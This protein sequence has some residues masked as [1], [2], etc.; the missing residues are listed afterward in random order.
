MEYLS[1]QET[2][3]VEV[4]H[5][6]LDKFGVQ[7]LVKREDLNHKHVSGNKW[8][9][10]KYNLIE[11]RKQGKNT[12]LTFGG[13][14]SNHIYATAAAAQILGFK[15]IGVIRGEETF[16]LNPT[17]TFA[18]ENGMSLHY[19]SREAYRKKSEY[20]TIDSLRTLFG[21]FYLI[22][23]GGTNPLAVMGTS[24]FASQL[25]ESSFDYILLAVGTGGTI[26]GLI[27]EFGGQRKIIGV[28]VFKGGDYLSEEIVTLSRSG[29]NKEHDNWSFWTA[30]HHGGYAKTTPQLLDFIKEIGEGCGMPLDH[31]YTGKLFY[32][33]FNE[34]K[35]GTFPRGTSLLAVHT[36][37]LQGAL[38]I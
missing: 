14:Y 4:T 18:V 23:E 38:S 19:L 25:L 11:A 28:P 32:A 15:S 27:K 37:G 8:W 31:V 10:L 1:Y 13:A 3:I 30:Y 35:K 7:L 26:A 9:K 5:P 17:L 12:L 24:E 6:V 2:P 33:I 36:G 22:P 20:E 21:D 34:V 29:A 16:P